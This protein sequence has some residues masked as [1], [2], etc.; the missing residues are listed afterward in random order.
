ME[1]FDPARIIL[2]ANVEFRRRRRQLVD[3]AHRPFEQAVQE[4][5]KRPLD[6]PPQAK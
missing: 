3:P 4:A 2:L 5:A 6:N 1:Q